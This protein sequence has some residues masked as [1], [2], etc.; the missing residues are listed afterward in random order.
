MTGPH[1]RTNEGVDAELTYPGRPFGLFGHPES[2]GRVD[3]RDQ[4]RITVD[5]QVRVAGRRQEVHLFADLRHRLRAA[6]A[7]R[8][9]ARTAHR[10]PRGGRPRV[11]QPGSVPLGAEHVL[12]QVDDD[13]V[14]ETGDRE[15]GQFL[16]GPHHV[17]GSADAG[18]GFVDQRQ[19]LAGGPALGDVLDHVADPGDRVRPVHQREERGGV[20]VPTVRVGPAPSEVLVVGHR[21][22]RDQHLAHQP[23]DGLRL[24]AG[25]QL[26]QPVP[27]PLV[28]R[29]TAEPFQRV[30]QPYIAQFQIHHGHADR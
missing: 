29:H 27:Q 21:L 23:L 12:Q 19:E 20:G 11:A 15:V 9:Q 30:V 1:R 8:P 5:E 14:R 10:R 13:E 4:D 25:Q 2:V 3:D 22:P 18:A 24:Q 28:P 7:H 26:A 17:E 16:R 6:L